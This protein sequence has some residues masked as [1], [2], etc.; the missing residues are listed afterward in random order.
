MVIRKAAEL[1]KGRVYTHRSL[2]AGKFRCIKGDSYPVLQNIRSGWTLT[3]H[4]VGMYED[5]TIDWDYSTN[6]RFTP[7]PEI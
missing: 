5:G 2:V 7:L 1:E 4:G 3:A 6:G